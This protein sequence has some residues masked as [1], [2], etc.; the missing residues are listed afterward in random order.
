MSESRVRKWWQGKKT[1]AANWVNAAAMVGFL[2]Y[3]GTDPEEAMAFLNQFWEWLAAGELL[4]A[5]LISWFR[6]LGKKTDG[7]GS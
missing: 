6:Q 3:L 2:S 5:G 1:H 4:A 7:G